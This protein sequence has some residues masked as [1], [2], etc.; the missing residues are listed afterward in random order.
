MAR[1]ICG[2]YLFYKIIYVH[3]IEHSIVLYIVGILIKEY[4]CHVASKRDHY[5]IEEFRTKCG[6]R[7]L[8]YWIGNF[9]VFKLVFKCYLF[10]NI[11]YLCNFFS[12]LHV[13]HMVLCIQRPGEGTGFPGTWVM[14]INHCLVSGNQALVLC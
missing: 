14:I 5:K 10:N 11:I 9:N 13:Y 3:F 4:N 1:L 7:K 8:L 2:N 12:Y 6:Y